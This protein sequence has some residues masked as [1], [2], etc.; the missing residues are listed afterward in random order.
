M[1]KSK[2]YLCGNMPMIK[3]VSY[4]KRATVGESSHSSCKT[5]ATFIIPYFL[6]GRD[7]W[8]R[9]C[10]GNGWW[11]THNNNWCFVF[12]RIVP[13]HCEAI[14]T[15]TF[16]IQYLWNITCSNLMQHGASSKVSYIINTRTTNHS[17][18]CKVA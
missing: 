16:T 13:A 3:T 10:M 11:I 1:D 17:V 6:L 18:H 4:K 15:F 2:L 8:K 12:G 5:L 14:N 7:C 9:Q